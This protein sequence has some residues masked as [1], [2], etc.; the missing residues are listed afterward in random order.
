M[1]ITLMTIGKNGDK[2]LDKLFGRYVDRLSHY[3]K[4][5]TK[6]LPDA[7]VSKSDSVE[8]QKEIEGRNILSAVSVNDFVVLLDEKGNQYSSLGF[9]DYIEKHL[10][11]GTRNL[12]FVIGG[13]Y[14]FSQD[15][16]NRS[17]LLISLSQMTLTHEMVRLFFIEQLYRAFTIIKGENYHHE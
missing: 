1:K 4:F 3:V 15:V 16:Y 5:E 17:D 13:P 2:E 12:I 10:I 11:R 6:C 8:R 9:A 7:K 14:G